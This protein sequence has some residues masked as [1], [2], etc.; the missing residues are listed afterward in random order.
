M[1]K[2]F[3]NPIRVILLHGIESAGVRSVDRI[4]HKLTNL[5]YHVED[6]QLKPTFWWGGRKDRTWRENLQRIAA[7][8]QPGDAVVA[9]SNGCRLCYDMIEGGFPFGDLFWFAPALDKGLTLKQCCFR[10]LEVFANPHDKALLWGSLLPGHPWGA[11]GRKG[12]WGANVTQVRTM[13][14]PHRRGVGHGHYFEGELLDQVVAIID[15]AL[16]LGMHPVGGA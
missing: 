13:W 1:T 14:F 6:V 10:N 11:M 7:V 3:A 16:R 9:H 8:A 2:A 12:Y 4:G 15:D 5:G